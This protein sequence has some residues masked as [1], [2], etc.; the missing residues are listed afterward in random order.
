MI[1]LNPTDSRPLYEQIE[2]KIKEMIIGGF[3]KE[4]DKIP[5]VRELAQHLAINPNTIQKAYKQLEL[6]GY[7]F[8]RPAKG[9]FV[10][11]P[12][13]KDEKFDILQE[14]FKD[15]IK[16]MNFLGYPKEKLNSLIDKYYKE[17]ELK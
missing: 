3:L 8:A 13:K 10:K 14:Q 16:E 7:I 12:E 5:S 17:E 2:E 9:Y 11:T 6:D 15:L 4:D 1:I